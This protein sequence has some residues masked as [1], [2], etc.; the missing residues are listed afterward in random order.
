MACIIVWLLTFLVEE[1]LVG[2][3]GA[4]LIVGNLVEQTTSRKG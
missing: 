4:E 3:T 1:I 2:L